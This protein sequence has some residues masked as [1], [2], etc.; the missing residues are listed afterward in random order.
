MG[1]A[2]AVAEP[3]AS[4]AAIMKATWGSGFADRLRAPITAPG[5]SAP[6]LLG[7]VSSI[8]ADPVAYLMRSWREYGDVVQFPIPRPPSYLVASAEGVRQVLVTNARNYGKSTIQYK[9]LA[10]VTGEGLLVADTAAWRRQRPAVQPAFHHSTLPGLVPHV[11]KAGDRLVETWLSS[12]GAVVD[13]DQAML[14]AALEVVGGSL[15]GAD[16][17]TDARELTGATLAGLDE[18]IARSRTPISPPKWVPTGSNRRLAR[19]LRTLDGAVAHI[20]AERRAASDGLDVVGLLRESRDADGNPLSDAEI[21]NQI[22]TFIVA[23]HE[24]VASAL[25][26]AW[27]LLAAHPEVQERLAGEAHEVIGDRVPGYEDY[28]RLPYARA[29]LDETLRL[30]PPAW[31][32]TRK[33]LGPD[34]IDGHQIP[35]GALLILSPWLVHRHPD[36]WD[37]PEEFDPSRFIEG[38]ADRNAFLPYGA[39]PRLCIGRDF[40]YVEGVLL[41]AR[42]AARFT[43]SYPPGGSLPAANPMVTVRPAGGLPLVLAPRG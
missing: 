30:Y 9:S 28:S 2:A 37:S 24:T 36:A 22:V 33:S 4:V 17:S 1:L 32:I 35:A 42:L 11:T 19:A 14:E 15:F 31:L 25:S 23:G 38:R 21:R 7:E 26:W 16:L 43:F 27:A 5:P 40:A 6:R 12:P 34:Q 13:V 3:T 10:L 18:V 41:L 39:G 29:V 20:L 8:F